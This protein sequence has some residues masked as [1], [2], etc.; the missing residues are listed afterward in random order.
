[1][2]L[3][4]QIPAQIYAGFRGKLRLATLWR[5]VPSISAGLDENGDPL[6]AMIETWA[7]QGFTDKYSD[8]FRLKGDVPETDAKVCIFGASLPVGI[9]PQKDDK[10]LIAGQWWQIR[11]PQTDPADA[12]WTCQS[13]VCAAPTLLS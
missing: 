2:S 5:S 8:Y 9:R 6:A 13:F 7:C 11:N 1:V 10:V 12:L 4:D 3:L